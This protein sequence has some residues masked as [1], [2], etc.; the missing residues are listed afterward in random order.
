M[1]IKKGEGSRG[2][3]IVGHTK[4]GKAIYGSPRSPKSGVQI[5]KGVGLVG[6]GLATGM[7]TGYSVARL[8]LRRGRIKYMGEKAS[9]TARKLE[10]DER[11]YAAIM[12]YRKG[13]SLLKRAKRVGQLEKQVGHTGAVASAALFAMGTNSILEHTRL[14]DNGKARAAISG[15]TGTAAAFTIR[16]T[17]HAAL[18]E[19]EPLAVVKTAAKT[20]IKK[21]LRRY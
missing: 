17:F 18:K 4:G 1:A 7:A 10:K 8:K 16:N 13:N 5:A 14:K 15:A 2:G 11:E 6:A 12:A 9:N 21:L 19:S 3:H 20:A